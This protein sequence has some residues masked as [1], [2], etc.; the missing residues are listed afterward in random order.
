MKWR[1]LA[2]QAARL[3]AIAWPR[4]G[5]KA[6]AAGDGE[7]RPFRHDDWQVLVTRFASGD[8]VDYRNFARVQRL[9]EGY[10]GRIARARPDLWSIPSEALAFYLNAYNA[11]AI[12]QV[13]QHYPVGSLP[14]IPLAFARPYP[15]GREL[16]SLNTLLH[17]KIRAFGDPRVHAAVVPAARSA[18]R[19]RAFTSTEL[20]QELDVAMRALLAD[21]VRGPRGAD[22]GQPV[23]LSPIFHCFAGDFAAPDR[24]PDLVM[25]MRG[26]LRPEIAL[27]YLRPYIPPAVVDHLKRPGTRMTW[28]PYDWSLNDNRQ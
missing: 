5:R 17:A 21:P 13:I 18:P 16:L 4:V 22:E 20:D 25:N 26:Y 15:V 7:A 14:E 6:P 9:L 12:H 8:G 24:M 3:Q 19:L 23:Q 11:I 1:R 2:E 28:L 27:P 10:L